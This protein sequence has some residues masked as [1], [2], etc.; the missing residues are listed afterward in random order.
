M[1][2]DL[3]LLITKMGVAKDCVYIGVDRNDCHKY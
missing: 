2:L 1:S 3:N